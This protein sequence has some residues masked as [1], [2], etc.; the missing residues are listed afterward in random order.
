MALFEYLSL[1]MKGTTFNRSPE[2]NNRR[3]EGFYR[4][5]WQSIRE[6]HGPALFDD[7]ME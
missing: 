6:G 7:G 1:Q 2:D 5:Y 4:K 3:K